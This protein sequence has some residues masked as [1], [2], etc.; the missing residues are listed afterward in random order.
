MTSTTRPVE[1]DDA[2]GI[3]DEQANERHQGNVPEGGG[4]PFS[5]SRSSGVNTALPN[6][7]YPWPNPCRNQVRAFSA[8]AYAPALVVRFVTNAPGPPPP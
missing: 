4:L 3:R 5:M 2:D 8:L 6:A 1:Q 7:K